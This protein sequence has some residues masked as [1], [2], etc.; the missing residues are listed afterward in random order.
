MNLKLLYTREGQ[1]RETNQQ[2][3]TCMYAPSPITIIRQRNLR[4]QKSMIEIWIYFLFILINLCRQLNTTTFKRPPSSCTQCYYIWISFHW[5]RSSF[6]SHFFWKI[7]EI[8]NKF[9]RFETTQHLQKMKSQLY[10]LSENTT[11]KKEQF[12][13]VWFF[14]QER[15]EHVIL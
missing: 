3:R 12:P 5:F 15:N 2:Q 6:E 4:L 10:S 1:R 7:V 14:Y 8:E 11:T 9:P 13:C